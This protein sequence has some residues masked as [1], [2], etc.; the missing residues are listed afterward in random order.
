M[1]KH[2]IVIASLL[3]LLTGC[4]TDSP[5]E[6]HL[7]YYNT[8]DFTPLW[9]AEGDER[10]SRLHQLSSF[11]FTDQ[12]NKAVSD[13]TVRG[14][15]HVASFFFTS[16]PGLC[17]RLT[18]SMAEIQAAFLDNP[19]VVLLSYSVTPERDSVPALRAYA[20]KHQ[21]MD[22]KWHLLTGDHDAIYKLARKSYFADENI[23]VQKGENDFLHTENLILVD[24]E[25][26]IRGIYNGT[27]PLDV[28]Q[29][30]QD[31]NTLNGLRNSDHN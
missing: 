18:H 15:I 31:I 23:G 12:N 29:L 13:K 6:E 24:E 1:G 25:L 20:T 16:C 28:Q 8:A 4:K 9:L 27:L 26:H 17:P 21:V 3:L 2:L 5:K 14:K 7:P 19:Q 11:S 10:I 22:S 30:I